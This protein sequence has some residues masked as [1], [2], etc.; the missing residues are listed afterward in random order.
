MSKTYGEQFNE[1]MKCETVEQANAWVAKEV[2]RYL[3]EFGK[4]PEEAHQIILS[5]LGYMA[6]Y[7]DHEVAQKVH[8]LFG[9]IHPIFGSS[10]YHKDMTPKQCF[11]KG[12][13][14]GLTEGT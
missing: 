5:N 3:R 4:S 8:H 13:V 12:Y 1:A 2:E 6:G 9:A 10:T 7:Y 11:K 14:A